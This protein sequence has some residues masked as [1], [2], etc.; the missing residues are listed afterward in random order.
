[1]VIELQEPV[2]VFLPAGVDDKG[3]TFGWLVGLREAADRSCCYAWVQKVIVGKDR[4][5]KDWGVRQRS[6]KFDSLAEARAWA[7]RVARE[8]KARERKAK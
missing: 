8:R 7:Y 5:I 6:K 4:E 2:E 3:R 1:M